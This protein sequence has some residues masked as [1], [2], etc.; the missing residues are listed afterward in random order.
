MRP[1]G[2]LSETEQADFGF[3]L[4]AGSTRQQHGLQLEPATIR[5]ATRNSYYFYVKQ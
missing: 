3:L 1:E 4:L 5:S 2:R